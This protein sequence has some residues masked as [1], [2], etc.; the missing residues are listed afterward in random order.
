MI[1]LEIYKVYPSLNKWM[2]MHWSARSKLNEEWGWLVKEAILKARCGKPRIRKAK[3]TF[4]LE[5]PINRR[6]DQ[7]N[8]VQK[9]VMDWLVKFEILQDD[10]SDWVQ[11]EVVITNGKRTCTR[12]TIEEVTE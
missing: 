11:S 10:R 2:R 6:R 8:M 1:T 7:D 4:V 5:F 12:I 9:S 3:I